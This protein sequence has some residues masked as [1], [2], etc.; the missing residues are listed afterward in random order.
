MPK[1]LDPMWEYGLPYDGHNRM[2]LNCKFSGLGMFGDISYLK[3]HLAKIPR[4]EVG[5]FPTSTP[6]IVHIETLQINPF[7]QWVGGESKGKNPGLSLQIDLQAS[8]EQGNANLRVH[9]P[10]CLAPQHPHLSLCRGQC[11]WGNL[12]FSRW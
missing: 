1:P 7:L 11:L 4:I 9:I 5:I 2:R 3:Y 12:L 8:R 6:K 10:Q